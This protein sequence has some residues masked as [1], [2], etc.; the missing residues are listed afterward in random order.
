MKRRIWL[1][2]GL[3]LG[4]A[5]IGEITQPV[6]ARATPVRPASGAFDVKRLEA[7]VRMLSDTLGPRDHRHLENLDRVATYIAGEFSQVG[8]HPSDQTYELEE[9]TYLNVRVLLGPKTPE[10]IV[11]GAH[12]DSDGALPAADD[13]ASGV[14]VLLELAR[15][16]AVSPPPIET[17]LVAYT[18]EEES[19]FR[20]KLM[21]S[22]IHAR[23][24]KREGVQVKG[25]I[26]LEML[27][28]F[29]NEPDTQKFPLGMLRLFYPTRGNFIAVI[30]KVGGEGI[31]RRV[32]AAMAGAS[33]LPVYS[34][35]GPRSIPGIDFSDHAS[36]W[37][38][39][40]PAVMVTDTA[41]YRNANYHRASD[42]PETLDYGKMSQVGASVYAAAFALAK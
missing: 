1:A 4:A 7:H 2:G 10:R 9:K 23:S 38:E 32:K 30:G 28:Y 3:L 20:G 35:N 41:F 25:M 31:V 27:G 8:L 21:G 22:A 18:L 19:Q 42:R 24:L 5:L 33:E 15:A 12:Y 29:S 34:M 36:Y 13:N 40:Y 16:F 26:S 37:D 14:A 17:E 6:I 11:I 39:G